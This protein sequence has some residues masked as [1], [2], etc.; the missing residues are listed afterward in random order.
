[1]TPIYRRAASFIVIIAMATVIEFRFL[2]F[3]K[4]MAVG[5]TSLAKMPMIVK[6]IDRRLSMIDVDDVVV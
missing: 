3:D 6:P 2:S 4:W 5:P 1:M